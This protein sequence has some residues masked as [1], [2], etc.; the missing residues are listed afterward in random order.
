MR[1]PLLPVPTPHFRAPARAPALADAQAL[2]ATADLGPFPC[3]E[4]GCDGRIAISC[5]TL[6]RGDACPLRAR[7]V[8]DRP[9]RWLA[10]DRVEDLCPHACGRCGDIRRRHG[11]DVGDTLMRSSCDA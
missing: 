7:D 2:C 10:A 8:W 1:R 5:S 9:Q 6:A 11:G 4:E 3:L